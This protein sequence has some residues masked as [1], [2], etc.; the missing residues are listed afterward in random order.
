MGEYKVY[1]KYYNEDGTTSKEFYNSFDKYEDAA[2]AVDGLNEDPNCEAYIVDENK[3][4]SESILNSLK[5]SKLNEGAW[6]GKLESGSK[7]RE[8][9][10]EDDDSTE[11]YQRVLDAIKDCCNEAIKY[12]ENYSKANGDNFD[13]EIN[14]FTSVIE[15]IDMIYND[16][17]LDEGAVDYELEGL[18]DW[19]DSARLFLTL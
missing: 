1:I 17:D 2:K 12:L 8:L 15:D 14:G 5:K 6:I 4:L 7:L 3:N 10:R 13:Y 16:E 19:C 11:Y 9:I 18:Y